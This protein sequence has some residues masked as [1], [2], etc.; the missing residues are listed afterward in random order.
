MNLDRWLLT[1]IRRQRTAVRTIAMALPRI[2]LALI[3]GF[4]IAE[5]IV[6]H[7][8]EKEVHAQAVEDKQQEFADGVSKL[9]S[10]GEYREIPGLEARRDTLEAELADVSFGAVLTQKEYRQPLAQ[11][12][13]LEQRAARA[14]AQGR[15]DVARG[16]RHRAQVQR[17]ELLGLR[18]Q[19]LAQEKHKQHVDDSRKGA[20][21]AQVQVDLRR[22]VAARALDRAKLRREYEREIGLLDR[23]EALSTL[24]RENP[25][26]FLWRVMLLLF[27]LCLD[28]LPA[29]AKV[30]MSLGE[31]SL[32]ERV[33]TGLEAADAAAVEEH[34]AAYVEASKID[35]SVIV[36]EAQARKAYTER[37]QTGLVEKA[38]RTMRQAGERFLDGWGAAVMDN[39]DD[40]VDEELRRL[41]LRRGSSSQGGAG[42][43]P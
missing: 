12:Q 43:S 29:I 17:A 34:S 5:P 37:E 42:Q 40:L 21:L 7:V 3:V 41:G 13:A 20:Q 25:S 22:L 32:Y 19:L 23:V 18:R 14:G 8:F 2:A 9:N 1:S 35:A 10:D 30:L 26:M 39:V 4:V 6:L 36:S 16:L 33:Q 24:T 27:I 38:A 15:E 28:S 31:L 11:V